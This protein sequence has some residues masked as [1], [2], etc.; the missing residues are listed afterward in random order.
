MHR[1]LTGLNAAQDLDGRR[2]S[3]SAVLEVLCRGVERRGLWPQCVHPSAS[4]LTEAS[5]LTRQLAVGSIG[6]EFVQ[7][8]LP[9]KTVSPIWLLSLARR[10]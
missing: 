9:Y 2:D 6:S 8:L 5:A 3:E 4:R 7:G 10:C 1:E